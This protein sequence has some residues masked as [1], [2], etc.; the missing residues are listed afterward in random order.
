[1]FLRDPYLPWLRGSLERP[2][3]YIP[4]LVVSPSPVSPRVYSQ[5]VPL[6]QHLE[7][8]TFT[9]THTRIGICDSIPIP[10]GRTFLHLYTHD[11]S[12]NHLARGPLPLISLDMER[13]DISDTNANTDSA[14]PRTTA[15]TPLYRIINP[16]YEPRYLSRPRPSLT[17]PPI[18]YWRSTSYPPTLHRLHLS[19]TRVMVTGTTTAEER[20]HLRQDPQGNYDL[21]TALHHT[22]GTHF[23]AYPWQEAMFSDP[24]PTIECTKRPPCSPL[25]PQASQQSH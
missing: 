8:T 1:M 15:P 10:V 2:P 7:T 17:P 11:D 22:R 12:I 9:P 20:A 19:S 6:P 16:Q 14:I 24:G 25:M 18:P 5:H 3:R 13:K 4:P 23:L 21:T